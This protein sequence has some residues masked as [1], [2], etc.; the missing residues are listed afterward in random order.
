MKNQVWYHA[1]CFDGFGAAYAAWFNLGIEET[2]YHPVSYNSPLPDYDDPEL[3]TIYIVD[4]SIKP[5]EFDRLTSRGV[6]IV[7]LDHHKSAFEEYAAYFGW[8]E[9]GGAYEQYLGESYIYFNMEYSGAYLTW[10]YFNTSEPPKLIQYISDR[11]LWKF[12]LENSRLIHAMLCTYPFEFEVY[13]KLHKSL[14]DP[15][16]EEVLLEEGRVVLRYHDLLIDKICHDAQM[17]QIDEFRVPMV[18]TNILFSE[19]PEALTKRYPDAE[20]AIYKYPKGN[21]MIQYGFRSRNDFDVSEIAARYGGGGHKNAAGCTVRDP[22]EV[23]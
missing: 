14:E 19:V 5:E 15:Q 3:D 2:S 9:K 8:E 7:L 20:F 16:R 1:G 18:Y 17:V 21:G 22:I 6:R 23:I 13:S 11:D 4:F 10:Q 12:R